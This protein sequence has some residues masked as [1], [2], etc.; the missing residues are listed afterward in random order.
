MI[1]VARVIFSIVTKTVAL[2]EPMVIYKAGGIHMKS[3][4][5]TQQSI[6]PNYCLSLGISHGILV[7]IEV[8][9]VF[10]AY[11]A[12]IVPMD[13][14]GY[15]RKRSPGAD[16]PIRECGVVLSYLSKPPCNVVSFHACHFCEMV[17]AIKIAV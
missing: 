6:N 13:T 3:E 17:A 10:N 7:P 4:F 16:R 2:P 11:S 15:E 14:G 5:K 12:R 9:K 8:T 1:E